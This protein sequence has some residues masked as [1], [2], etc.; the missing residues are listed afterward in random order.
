MNLAK[1][2]VVKGMPYVIPP[3]KPKLN[4]AR[5]K[6]PLLNN[7]EK[8]GRS[9]KRNSAN[10]M[11]QILQFDPDNMTANDL[12]NI[13]SNADNLM[14]LI[15]SIKERVSLVQGHGQQEEEE[16]P[17]VVFTEPYIGGT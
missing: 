10:P 15:A 4:Y 8:S 6:R 1:S 9:P 13:A 12:K 16:E 2:K 3:T 14:H 17:R 5:P 7:R 11:A